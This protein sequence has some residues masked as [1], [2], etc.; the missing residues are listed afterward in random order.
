MATNDESDHAFRVPKKPGI[1]R[2]LLAGAVAAGCLIVLIVGAVAIVARNTGVSTTSSPIYALLGALIV[3]TILIV[4]GTQGKGP[5][6]A[7][8]GRLPRQLDG[9]LRRRPI[10]G[11]MSFTLTA[12]ALI[13]IARLSC[14]MADPALRWGSAYPPVEF[15]VSHMC[16]SAYVQA[17]DLSR[18]HDPNVYAEEHY[19]AY[20]SEQST[21]APPPTTSVKN[22]GP[23]LRDAYEYPP[24]FLLLPRAALV[25]TND[26]L[27]IRTGWFML[28]LPLF[29][30]LA[31]ALA[32]F[33]GGS[34]GMLA[35]LLVPAMLAS[36]PF[37]FNFQFGQFHLAAI[38][39]AVAGMLLF[40]RGRNVLGGA[41]L[42]GALV[43]KVFP[44]LLLVYL[45]VRRQ[46]RPILWTMI[47]A[48]I[49]V[50]IGFFVVGP[51]PYRAFFEYHLPRLASG[52]AFRFN[53]FNDLTL[54]TNASIFAI[55]FKLQRLGVPGM[56][57]QTAIVLTW[58]YT[59]ALFV[60]AIVAARTH[61]L[62]SLEPLIWLGLLTLGSLRSPDAPNV[63]IGTS[64]LWA[65]TFLAVETRGH[66]THVGLFA[67]VWMIVN[68]IPPPRDPEATIILWMFCQLVLV[69]VGFFLVL[70]RPG[71]AALNTG[72]K[73]S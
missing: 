38:M 41:L 20:S 3:A 10:V 7:M 60:V 70:H 39:L 61:R 19:P 55:P 15:G 73:D 68:V 64:A 37:L 62:P 8:A 48:A 18:R 6:P 66:V 33:V 71:A 49:Y 65:L 4:A 46:G 40:S 47:F 32:G 12:V 31:L 5:L 57:V 43:T 27:M 17:G 25:L 14:F 36:F 22:L 35:G 44:G 11:W 23:Y 52:E 69:L 58:F 54:A 29:C 50:V 16:I 24:P 9:A 53:L 45:A 13:Q 42:A 21:N 30:A 67:A 2:L 56:S 63:Y 59:A 26:F 51:E 28:Q 1:E 72:G 34:R